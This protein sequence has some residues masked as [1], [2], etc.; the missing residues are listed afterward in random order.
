VNRHYH[1]NSHTYV[2]RVN[3]TY[4]NDLPKIVEG[5]ILDIGCAIGVTSKE[6]AG[7]YLGCKTI[8]LDKYNPS[9]PFPYLN[10]PTWRN[11]SS[12]NLDFLVANGYDLPFADKV[13]DGVF[14]MNNLYPF[15]MDLMDDSAVKDILH[16]IKRKV[17][18]GGYISF[19]AENPNMLMVI[20]SEILGLIGVQYYCNDYFTVRLQE[21]NIDIV[22]SKVNWGHAKHC[23]E[24]LFRL[25]K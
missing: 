20:G 13:F 1:E 9:M 16:N 24:R 6:L 22:S 4:N 11:L 8:G 5:T 23:K 15:A 19:A 14:I 17:K 3:S 18:I 7:I 12:C 10:V 2:N 21:N 25:L